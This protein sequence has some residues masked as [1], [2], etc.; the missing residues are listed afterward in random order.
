MAPAKRR[1]STLSRQDGKIRPHPST[2]LITSAR[3][4]KLRT[5]TPAATKDF[6]DVALAQMAETDLTDIIRLARRLLKAKVASR[7]QVDVSETKR[8]KRFW[9]RP[10]VL[11]WNPT[12]IPTVQYPRA[13]AWATGSDK[14]W[15][16][17]PAAP[18]VMRAGGESQDPDWGSWQML[19]PYD[20]YSNSNSAHGLGR[21]QDVIDWTVFDLLSQVDGAA[22]EP[23]L[24]KNDNEWTLVALPSPGSNAKAAELCLNPE[25][26]A[27]W[28][29]GVDWTETRLP[30]SSCTS[31]RERRRRRR[32]TERRVHGHPEHI[33]NEPLALN[34]IRAVQQ[35]MGKTLNNPSRQHPTAIPRRA[36]H[37]RLRIQQPCGGGR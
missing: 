17:Q 12:G 18:K 7:R 11:D 26:D 14:E 16:R 27:E 3:S 34:V 8:P 6:I 10:L 20:A 30:F 24:D 4:S 37:P 32:N 13:R 1:S 33:S 22:A 2:A 19:G 28:F 15:T 31:M 23:V 25:H 21:K 9:E 5:L 29:T 36:P 35:E